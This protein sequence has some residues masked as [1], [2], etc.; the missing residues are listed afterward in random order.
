[1]RVGKHWNRLLR[2]GVGISIPIDTQ[3]LT[4]HDSEQPVLIGHTL[5][6]G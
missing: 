6:R 5:S 2:P 4:G 1:M 3:T